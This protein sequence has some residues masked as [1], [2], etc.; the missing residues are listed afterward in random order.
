VSEYFVSVFK[1]ICEVLFKLFL[2]D[3]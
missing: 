2:G 3:I 1:A